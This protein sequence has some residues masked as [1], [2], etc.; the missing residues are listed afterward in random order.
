M[1]ALS[2]PTM[3]EEEEVVLVEEEEVLVLTMTMTVPDVIIITIQIAWFQA[4]ECLCEGE[5]DGGGGVRQGGAMQWQRGTALVDSLYAQH[6]HGPAGSVLQQERRR[7][8]RLR[9]QTIPEKRA[10]VTMTAAAFTG[11]YAVNVFYTLLD[12]PINYRESPPPPPTH[13]HA[14]AHALARGI[15]YTH[16]ALNLFRF[17][18]KYV[19]SAN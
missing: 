16:L 15:S 9:S 12:Y 3:G 13:P 19:R 6:A 8:G 17:A 7:R 10:L 18:R 2:A 14:R 1:G 4:N 11:I 5:T